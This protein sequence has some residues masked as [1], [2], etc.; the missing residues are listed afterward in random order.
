MAE[1]ISM[2]V[3]L[4]KS[5]AHTIWQFVY[6]YHSGEEPEPLFTRFRKTLATKLTNEDIL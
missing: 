5:P 2:G 4:C 1:P 3:S 6:F